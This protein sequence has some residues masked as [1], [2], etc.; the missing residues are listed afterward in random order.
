VKRIA[1][2]CEVMHPPFDEGIRIFAAELARALAR[3]HSLL[4]L[5]ERDGMLDTLPIHG[6]LT[7]RYFLSRRLADLIDDFGPEGVVYIPW[8]SL[9][10]RTLVRIWAL[11]KY[12]PGSR[13]GLISLQ[14]RPVDLLSRMLSMRK[15]PDVV[16]STGPSAGH[17]ARRLGFHTARIGA[18]VDRAR[19]RPASAE[20][21]AELRRRAGIDPGRFVV[22]HVGHLKESRNVGVLARIAGLD[23]VSCLL[24]ASTST[25]A[26]EELATLL[27]ESGVIVM[28]H[29]QDRIEFAYR[30]ADAY[31]FPVTTPLDAI[32]MPL[33]VLEAAACGLSI[34]STPFGGLP[35][36]LGDSAIWVRTQEEM[37]D[38]IGSLARGQVAG[39][40]SVARA[41]VESQTWERVAADVVAAL[42]SGGSR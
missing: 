8:T 5:S 15:G 35:D 22:L 20:Q 10:A 4:L 25:A 12:A 31:L 42:S 3:S 26:R 19:F 28:T 9:T 18:G 39:G 21:R 34:V 40:A 16:M 27:R 33:S 29:H 24:V 17:Q 37:V 7:D 23:G 6:A 41:R 14:P 11:R 36:L 1:V 30:L 32:E 2:L 38:A 13:I